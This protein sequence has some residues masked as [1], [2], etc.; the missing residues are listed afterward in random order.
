MKK[1]LLSLIIVLSV[2]LLVGCKDKEVKEIESPDVIE[3]EGNPTTGYEWTCIIDDDSIAKLEAIF[4]ADETTSA[5]TGEGGTYLFTVTGLKEGKTTIT[6]KYARSWE[7]TDND[8]EKHFNVTVN[9]DLK[10][11]IEEIKK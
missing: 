6:C 11:S 8:E 9:K 10:A 3:L 5:I 4:E 1:V 2:F 7:K